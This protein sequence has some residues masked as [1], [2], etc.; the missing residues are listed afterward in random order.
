MSHEVSWRQAHGLGSSGLLHE[1]DLSKEHLELERALEA[2]GLG[3][4]EGRRRVGVFECERQS[5]QTAAEPA[6][7]MCARLKPSPI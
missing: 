3:I 5:L 4:V 2:Q 6:V 7:E 1:S